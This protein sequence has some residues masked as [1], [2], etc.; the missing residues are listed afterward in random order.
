VPEKLNFFAAHSFGKD[1][2]DDPTIASSDGKY[3]AAKI[4]NNNGYMIEGN[5][6]V[7]PEF[8]L[9]VRYDGFDPTDE[10]EKQQ[11]VTNTQQD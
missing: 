4:G 10:Q 3:S 2:V 11:K 5:Y 6:H 1:S 7:K 8:A 9:R